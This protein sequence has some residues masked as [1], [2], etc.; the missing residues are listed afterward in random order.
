[1]HRRSLLEKKNLEAGRDL[2]FLQRPLPK[3]N[4]VKDGE[5]KN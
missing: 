3:I 4:Y 1:M 2:R 5:R